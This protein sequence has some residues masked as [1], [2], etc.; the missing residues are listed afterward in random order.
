MSDLVRLMDDIDNCLDNSKVY[1]LINNDKK[2]INK[3]ESWEPSSRVTLI[4]CWCS[5][6]IE[7][8]SANINYIPWATYRS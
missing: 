1:V 5:L 7:K 6:D 3:L 4:D 2:F 8:I